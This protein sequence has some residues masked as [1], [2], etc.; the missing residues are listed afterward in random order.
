MRNW[1]RLPADAAVPANATA[2]ATALVI[3]ARCVGN[4]NKYQ[5]EVTMTKKEKLDLLISKVG[6]DKKEEL[7]AQLQKAESAEERFEIVKQ[8]GVEFTDEEKE[9][10]KAASGNKISDE[11]LDQAAGGCHY[12]CDCICGA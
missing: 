12:H 4:R 7:I 3:D 6:E 1:I 10:L 2:I 11:E 8:F 9:M 5:M